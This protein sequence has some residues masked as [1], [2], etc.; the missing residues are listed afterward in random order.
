M[1]EENY[2]WFAGVDWGSE[3]HQAC[4]VDAQ[5]ASSA[6][7]SFRTAV[8][9]WLSLRLAAVDCRSDRDRCAWRSRCRT[10]RLSIP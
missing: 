5:A 10:D 7:G 9:A 1:A 2:A 4:L 8:R 6:S 3:R